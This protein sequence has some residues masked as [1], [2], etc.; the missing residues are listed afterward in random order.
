MAKCLCLHCH[1]IFVIGGVGEFPQAFTK[2]AALELYLGL[3]RL[4]IHFDRLTVIK[5][6]G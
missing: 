5:K 3:L 1:V 4:P 2:Q 6:T